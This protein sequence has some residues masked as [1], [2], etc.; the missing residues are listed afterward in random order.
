MLSV[1][2]NSGLG[3]REA[4]CI[5]SGGRGGDAS[6]VPLHES[7]NP[8]ASASGWRIIAITLAI[9]CMPAASVALPAAD[10]H[11]QRAIAFAGAQLF[12]SAAGMLGSCQRA[13]GRGTLPAGTEC[14][15]ATSGTRDAAAA[16]M[17]RIIGAQC[18]ETLG[19][20][21]PLGGDCA[22]ARNAGAVA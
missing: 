5:L 13:I 11:C 22:D 16:R 15:A 14:L 10:R 7:R 19:G 18:D 8:V 9:A 6:P 2:R 12:K 1:N 4:S 21:L 20:G 17:A 3:A